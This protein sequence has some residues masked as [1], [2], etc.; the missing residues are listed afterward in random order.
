MQPEHSPT[1]HCGLYYSHKPEK[2]LF[3]RVWEDYCKAIM[4]YTIIVPT[5]TECFD[6]EKSVF[7]PPAR[8]V[9][10]TKDLVWATHFK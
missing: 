4:V 3:G 10:P 6:T 9:H 5:N 2:G 1:M 7:S 8:I